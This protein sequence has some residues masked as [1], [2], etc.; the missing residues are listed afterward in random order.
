MNF[1]PGEINIICTDI[2]RSLHFYVNVLHFEVVA[3]ED[4]C[5]H[6]RCGSYV[7]LLLPVAR[8]P[9]EV[10]PYCSVPTFSADLLTPDLEAAYHYFLTHKIAFERPWKPGAR[11]FIIRDPDGL[12]WEIIGSQTSAR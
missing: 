6:L 8:Q 12:V 1:S 7:F 10:S 3:V 4:D 11:S 9:L 5:Y 2:Q